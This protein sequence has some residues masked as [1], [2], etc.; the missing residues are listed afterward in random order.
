M[1]YAEYLLLNQLER[2]KQADPAPWM[3]ASEVKSL[4][5]GLLEEMTKRQLIDTYEWILN[6]GTRP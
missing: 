4:I 3:T 2:Q 6:T 5:D 1:S